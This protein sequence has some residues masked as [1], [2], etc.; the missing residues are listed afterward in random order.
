G[1]GVAGE[2]GRLLNL[3]LVDELLPVSLHSYDADE[4]FFGNVLV[5]ITFGDQLEYF[6]FTRSEPAATFLDGFAT[7]N[8]L[9]VMFDQ[10][11]GDGR[12]E[13]GV[14]FLRFANGHHQILRGGRFDEVAGRSGCGQLLHIL[15]VAITS[16]DDDF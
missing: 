8:S 5:V 14:A 3:R 12:T 4:E 11:F 6:H 7:R 9:S 15:I 13:E 16:A 2:V 1:N 10:P